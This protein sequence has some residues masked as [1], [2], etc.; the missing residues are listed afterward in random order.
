MKDQKWTQS[1]ARL[2]FLHDAAVHRG[3]GE[4]LKPIHTPQR[5]WFQATPLRQIQQQ[6]MLMKTNKQKQKQESNID[7]EP[8]PTTGMV[9]GK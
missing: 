3:Q 4:Q 5:A 6:A 8:H 1:Q 9:Q 7:A 2:S